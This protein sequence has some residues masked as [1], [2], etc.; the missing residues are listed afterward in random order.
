[1]FEFQDKTFFFLA[2]YSS[3]HEGETFPRN[4]IVLLKNGKIHVCVLTATLYFWTRGCDIYISNNVNSF[5]I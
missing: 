2:L 3:H 1:M 5:I 4:L